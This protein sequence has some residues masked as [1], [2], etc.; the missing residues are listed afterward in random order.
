MRNHSSLLRTCW[1]IVATLCLSADSNCSDAADALDRLDLDKL[2]QLKVAVET[3]KTDRQPVTRTSEFTDYRACLH[4]HSFLSHDS[5]GTVEEIVKA[6]KEVGVRVLMFTNHPAADYDF[7]TDGHRGLVDGVLLIPG[8]ETTGLLS[9][10]T[11]SVKDKLGTEPQEFVDAVQPNGGMSFLCHLEERMDWELTG[12]TGSEIYN[13]HADFKDEARFIRVLRDPLALMLKLG[14]AL[15][16]YP[17]GVFAALQNYPADYLKKW[18]AMCAVKPHTGVS[19]NDAH[20][21]QG[22]KATIEE[23]GHIRIDDGLGEKVALIDPEKL[24]LIKPLLLGKKAGDV[25]FDLDLDPYARSLHHVSTHLLMKDLTEANV[26][27]ALQNGRAY[28]AFDWI[29]DPT[30]FLFQLETD[31]NNYEMGHVSPFV[32]SMTLHAA[33]PLAGSFRLI[34]NGVEVARE[35]GRSCE[36]PVQEPGIYRVEVWLNL[37]GEPRIWILSNPIYIREPESK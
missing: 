5:N 3:L 36:F 19:A 16:E 30:G 31:G 17:Q 28:V 18:D 22:L 6:A 20:H 14:P 34:R 25:V 26:R 13:T 7:F 10:P 21:N 4:V 35:L 33:A 8:A 37:E 1:V 24:P 27:E 12:L 2:R 9:F 29:A 11:A 23:D 15:R 32:S